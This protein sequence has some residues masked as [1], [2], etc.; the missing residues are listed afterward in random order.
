MAFLAMG[1]GDAVGPFVGLAKEHF[2][3]SNLLAQCI[4]LFGFAMFGVL[5]APMGVWQ[6]RRGKKFVL[7]LGLAIMLTGILIPSI[8]GLSTFRV[9]LITIMLLGAGATTLQVAGNPIMRDVSAEGKYARNLSLG[10]FVKA[11]GSLSGPLV[12][13]VAARWFGASWEVIFPVYSVAVLL[14]LL[15]ALS[16]PSAEAPRAAAATL[17]SSLAL[18]KN[19]FVAIMVTAIFLYVGA[20]V[21]MSASIPIYLKDRFAVDISQMGLLGTGLFFLSLTIGRF[22]GG[23]IL[24]W[25]SSR[26]FFVITSLLSVAGIAGLFL[27]DRTL[28]VASLV[29]IGLGFANIFPLIFSTVVDAMPEHSN[30]L[31]GLMV[32]AIV[33]GAI[34]PPIMG[35]VA[36]NLGSIR[37]A[38]LVPLA[39]ILYI[40][41]TA[42]ARPEPVE[43]HPTE[44]YAEPLQK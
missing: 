9:F 6:D 1:F 17:R 14:A 21:S 32:A 3:L 30:E 10:Q 25:I 24:S 18:L 38:L 22:S 41:W 34:V 11:I 2:Q 37:A 19:S 39:A 35:L 43:A 29:V 20:E 40:T 26:T 28:A 13:V 5:S 8:M 15:A 16:L 44:A 23:L 12:P 7:I 4:P 36:D 31:S 27:P 42:I 33:G